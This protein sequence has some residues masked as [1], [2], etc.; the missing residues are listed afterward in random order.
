MSPALAWSGRTPE[1]SLGELRE[2]APPSH[3]QVQG[4]AHRE[5]GV[6]RALGVEA[7]E[8]LTPEEAVVGVGLGV[9]IGVTRGAA[10]SVA[11]EDHP[12]EV[13][14]A[15]VVLDEL[16]SEPVEQFGV[17]GGHARFA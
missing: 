17:G 1:R 15:P 7:A 9:C 6:A 10:V 11:R 14:E 2:E 8:V 16:G 12:V 13:L 5:H 4:S 3:L